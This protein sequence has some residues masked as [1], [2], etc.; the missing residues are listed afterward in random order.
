MISGFCTPICCKES[1]PSFS[2]LF[3]NGSCRILLILGFR[4]RSFPGK[5]VTALLL[6]QYTHFEMSYLLDV[7]LVSKHSLKPTKK[8]ACETQF[9]IRMFLS[10]NHSST[11]I[12]CLSEILI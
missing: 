8:K 11:I 4:I 2:P 3:L 7:L 1:N 9:Y 12:T 6:R 10:L 5:D